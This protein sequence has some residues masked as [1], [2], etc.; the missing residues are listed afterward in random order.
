M[1]AAQKAWGK[2][3]GPRLRA[4]KACGPQRR[5]TLPCNPFFKRLCRAIRQSAPAGVSQFCGTAIPNTG[6][7]AGHDTLRHT[8]R[9]KPSILLPELFSL[10][11]KAWALS[12]FGAPAWLPGSGCALSPSASRCSSKQFFYP[13]SC[14]SSALRSLSE[15]AFCS[16]SR[17]RPAL[18]RQ[19]SPQFCPTGSTLP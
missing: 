11:S 18:V 16:F 2:L 8:S 12:G 1:S 14:R 15:Q 5:A 9:A 4:E 6:S 19:F 10:R 3:R 17:P 7:G 13:F